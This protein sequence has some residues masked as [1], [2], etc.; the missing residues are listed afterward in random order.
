M[1]LL[2][3]ITMWPWFLF[4]KYWGEMISSPKLMKP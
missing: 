2:V 3:A 4:V 1:F